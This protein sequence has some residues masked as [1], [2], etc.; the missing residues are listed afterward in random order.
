MKTVPTV[1]LVDACDAVAL[2]DLPQEIQLALTD[3]AGAAR[4]GLLAMSVAAGMAVMQVMFEAEIS[5]VAGPKGKHDPNRAAIRHGSGRGSVTLGGRRVPVSRPRART[6]DGHEVPLGTYTHFASDDL[7]SQVVMERMLAGLATRR[8]ARTGEPVGAQIQDKQTSTSRSA[9]SRRFVKQT[10]TALAELMTR[11]LSGEDIT[12]LMLDGE[13]MAERCVVV[14]L[15]ITAD[16]TKKPVG[17]W[18][19]STENK[20][21][22]RSLLADLV[23]RGLRFDDGLLVVL[24]G[25]KALSAGV[26]EV[27]GDK[28]LVQRCTLHK[29]RNVADHLPDKEKAWVD[30]KLVRAFCNPDPEQGLR[31]AKDL[32][33]LLAKSYPGA[34]ASLREGL[35]EMFTVSRLG[36]DG[37]LAKTLTT[38]NPVDSMISIARTTNRN[39]TRWR[40]G[41]MVLRWTAAGML[42][43]ERSFRRVKGYKQMPQL[44]DALHR[45]AHPDT[46]RG[47]ETVGVA[48]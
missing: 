6:T 2:P 46:D 3:I 22:V 16:G 37:R 30:A 39:V 12:V 18:E 33:G 36:I 47:T 41:Q 28:A 20:T 25:A 24:D 42:N 8:H 48:A 1:R 5:D 17:L 15:A 27:F 32:A 31:N 43:A 23:E 19:G 21:V 45:H 44:V 9:I 14:A 11:D 7:L 40:D 35:E 13:H 4:E 34:S 26:R 10:E 29:R 38:S